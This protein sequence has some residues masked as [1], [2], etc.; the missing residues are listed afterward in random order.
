MCCFPDL[1]VELGEAIA[2]MLPDVRQADTGRG[3]GYG[4]PDGR[5]PQVAQEGL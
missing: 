4:Q 3:E 2:S 5:K 1:M